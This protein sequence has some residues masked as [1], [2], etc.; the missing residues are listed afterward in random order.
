MKIKFGTGGIRAVMG[1]GE[2]QLNERVIEKVTLGVSCYLKKTVEHP[3]VAICYDSRNN[4][5]DFARQTAKVFASRGSRVYLSETLMPT[6]FLSYV[7]RK[8]QCDLGVSITASHNGKEYNGYKVYNHEG[9]QITG[10]AAKEIQKEIENLRQED[11]MTEETFDDY[12]KKMMI[13]YISKE[14]F[15]VFIRDILS[16]GFTDK[17]SEELKVVYSPLNGAGKEC[18]CKI[19][20][21]KGVKNLFVVP[22]QSEPNG[23]FPTCPYPN[24]EDDRA[25]ELGIKLSEKKDAHLFLATDPDGDRVGV[26]AKRK[27]RYERLSG[28]QVGVLLLDYI[29][30]RKKETGQLPENPLILK[31]I[32]TTEM[33]R[34]IA[35]KYGAQVGDTLTG[36]KYIG[37]QLGYLE[38]NGELER[39]VFGVEESCGYLIGPYVRDKDGVGAAMMVCEMADE[40]RKQGKTLWDRLEELYEE[41][42]FYETVAKTK[43]CSVQEAEEYMELLREGLRAGEVPE[44]LGGK[45]KEYRDYMNK[46]DNLPAANVLKIWFEG[47]E[48]LVIRP[49]GTEP[50]IKFYQEKIIHK[51]AACR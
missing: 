11:L 38:K 8:E 45:V 7:I 25:M 43:S 44:E 40:Y 47:G 48:C 9:C 14:I 27:G 21:E 19:L 13:Q 42:G 6:P 50:K 16:Y 1:E 23:D 46:Q 4:S 41:Y 26:V 10:K 39:F 31:T 36:F 5:R 17:V 37:E 35:E 20:E 2:E 3:K 30:R 12:R 49:S 51:E 34:K 33:V 18:V 32:V 28:N 22:K 24:P 15:E 29:L